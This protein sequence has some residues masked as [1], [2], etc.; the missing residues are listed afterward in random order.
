[1]MVAASDD[2]SISYRMHTILMIE[3]EVAVGE[4]GGS[5]TDGARVVRCVCC[6]CEEAVA[7][8]AHHLLPRASIVL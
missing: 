3:E 8:F 7:G 1:M 5:G 4:E 2:P 6:S